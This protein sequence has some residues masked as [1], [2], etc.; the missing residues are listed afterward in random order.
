VMSRS[1]LGC[2]LQRKDRNAKARLRGHRR[3]AFLWYCGRPGPATAVPR[4]TY[5]PGFTFALAASHW[6]FVISR[7]PW[8]LHE[9]IPLQEFLA[10]LQEDCP[11]Q[12]LTPVHLI[13]ASC[14]WAAGVPI[15][16]NRIA[17]AAAIAMPD[18]LWDLIFV[19]YVDG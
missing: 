14:A 6:A 9:F 17:A 11:L 1:K 8:P 7:K 4:I 16:E 10:L 15:V 2:L 18:V 5:M 19:S 12:L 3:L 13:L